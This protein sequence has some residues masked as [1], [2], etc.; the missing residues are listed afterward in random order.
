MKYYLQLTD[1]E[2]EALDKFLRGEKYFDSLDKK[3]LE[4][5]K[6]K[7]SKI[8]PES[9]ICPV[10]KLKH[11]SPEKLESLREGWKNLEE[12]GMR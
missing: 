5:V 2:Y 1:F 9:K 7:M 3:S 10:L 8:L 6:M 12:S 11:I 4:D